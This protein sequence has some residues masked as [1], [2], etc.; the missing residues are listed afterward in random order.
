MTGG[1]HKARE[2]ALKALYEADVS[3]H[4]AVKAVELLCSRGFSVEG[5]G[6]IMELVS[7]VVEYRAELDERIRS[8]APTWPIEQI[9]PV[10]RNILRLA[11]FEILK[12]GTPI[13]V[14]INEAVE[15]AK[16]FGADNSPRFINGVL[17]AVSAM[18]EEG[19]ER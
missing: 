9:S 14:A 11:V 1:R 13:K 12:G 18:V 6:F 7:G 10:D 4:D 8:F 19:G 17:G 16:A 15:L 3:G 5:R 2:A